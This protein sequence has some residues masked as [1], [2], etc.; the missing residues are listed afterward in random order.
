MLRIHSVFFTICAAEAFFDFFGRVLGGVECFCYLCT[1]K[2]VDDAQTYNFSHTMKRFLAI[3]LLVGLA[4]SG[5]AQWT[6]LPRAKKR[7][8]FGA[9]YYVAPSQY[10]YSGV[11]HRIVGDATTRYDKAQ[12]I[13]LWLCDNVTFDR[14]RQIRT[15]D[16]TWQHR[17]A[18]CQGYCELF[19]RLGETVGVKTRLV[20][21]KCRRPVSSDPSGRLQ[22]HVWLCVATEKGDILVDPTWGAGYY[23]GGEFVRQAVPLRWFDVDPSWFVF[24][25]LPDNSR[26]QHLDEPVSDADFLRLPFVVP[27]VPSEEAEDPHETLLRALKG[28]DAILADT[29]E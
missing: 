14:S 25:H 24:T 13:Y 1:A 15:A 2:G 27:P 3:L 5:A 12:R 20:Y 29:I 26:R 18:V 28:T 11:A 7:A 17:A 9:D 6:S 23:R 4:V 21:G 10:D 8:V 22:D 19:Y 16:E